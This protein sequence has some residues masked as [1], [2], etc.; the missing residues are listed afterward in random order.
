MLRFVGYLDRKLSRGD[1]SALFKAKD[2]DIFTWGKR[3]RFL[4]V[5]LTPDLLVLDWKRFSS[6]R[7]KIPNN[8]VLYNPLPRELTQ[9]PPL[10][11]PKRAERQR[12]AEV[13]GIALEKDE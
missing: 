2:F 12:G 7:M 6:F 13:M 9:F 3:H 1:P 8:C 4:G 5:L 10:Y 11:S